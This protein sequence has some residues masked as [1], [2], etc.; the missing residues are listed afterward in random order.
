VRANLLEALVA[1]GQHG[2][3]DAFGRLVMDDPDVLSRAWLA[4]GVYEREVSATL[5][6]DQWRDLYG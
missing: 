4:V 6:R 3:R 1:A 2:R 5:L